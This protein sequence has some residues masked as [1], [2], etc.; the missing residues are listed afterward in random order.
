MQGIA[1]RPSGAGMPQQSG[2]LSIRRDL[3][4]WNA[5]DQPVHGCVETRGGYRLRLRGVAAAIACH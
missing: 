4:G 5:R 3:A 1:H 2:D